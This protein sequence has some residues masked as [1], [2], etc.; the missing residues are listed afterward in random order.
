MEQKRQVELAVDRATAV[1]RRATL[2]IDAARQSHA[3]AEKRSDILERRLESANVELR[4]T[5]AALAEHAT[6]IKGEATKH[7]GEMKDAKLALAEALAEQEKLSDL[8]ATERVATETARTEAATAR[9]I[10]A[11]LAAGRTMPRPARST[12]ARSGP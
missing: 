8:L 4:K 9:G 6:I 10:F 1:E 11:Q 12:K 7:A 5:Y 3:R 2:E